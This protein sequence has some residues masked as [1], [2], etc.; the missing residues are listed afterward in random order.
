MSNDYDEYMDERLERDDYEAEMDDRY[1]RCG[2]RFCYCM[3]ETEY[4]VTCGDCVTGAHQ[5]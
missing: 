4:G 3:T 1:E 5:G 2:C